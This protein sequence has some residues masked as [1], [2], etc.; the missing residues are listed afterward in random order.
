MSKLEVEV[1]IFVQALKCSLY[2]MT[3]DSFL[4]Q[5]NYIILGQEVSSR[6]IVKRKILFTN[7]D[8]INNVSR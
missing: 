1:T 2:E 4:L 6:I 5:L 7:L 8:Q 3:T